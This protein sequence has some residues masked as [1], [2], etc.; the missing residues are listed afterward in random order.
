MDGGIG[1][2]GR[3][4]GGRPGA[5]T[6]GRAWA[7]PPV[8]ERL[9]SGLRSASAAAAAAAALVGC[10]ALVGWALESA[11]LKGGLAGGTAM[12]AN[13][14]VA[15]VLGGISALVAGARREPG[16]RPAGAQREPRSEERRVGKE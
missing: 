4:G 8:V 7:A 12:K 14:A 6:E 13:A 9:A 16:P 1:G 15:I 11:L 3:S 2:A 10:L 5:H